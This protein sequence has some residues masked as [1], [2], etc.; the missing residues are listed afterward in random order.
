MPR[1]PQMSPKHCS[2]IVSYICNIGRS[3]YHIL[4]SILESSN[5]RNDFLKFANIEVPS[6]CCKGLWERQMYMVIPPYSIYSTIEGSIAVLKISSEL[7]TQTI[8][9]Y[10]KPW[11]PLIFSSSIKFDFFQNLIFYLESYNM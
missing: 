4:Y 7:P 2:E 10:C 3:I 1:A 11:S 5:P 6:L 8:L 9:S